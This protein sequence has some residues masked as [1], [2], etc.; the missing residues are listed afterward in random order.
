MLAR[1]SA[2]RSLLRL[3]F[4][5]PFPH[6]HCARCARHQ[7]TAMT[8]YISHTSIDCTNAFELATWWKQAL[9]YEDL[10]GDALAPGEP[11]CMI[12]SRTCHQLLFIEVPERKQTKNRIHFDLRPSQ[13]SRDAEVEHLISLGAS[14]VADFRNADGT[15]WVVLQDPEGNEFCVLRSEAELSE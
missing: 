5:R 13:R 2:G 14:Q 1:G 6:D 15:G 4:P 10:P 9:G 7:N 3:H 12:V 8:A 11:E